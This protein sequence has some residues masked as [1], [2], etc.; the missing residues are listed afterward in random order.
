MIFDDARKGAKAERIVGYVFIFFGLLNIITVVYKG[1]E[2]FP[3]SALFMAIV[4]VGFLINQLRFTYTSEIDV[5]D[6]REVRY[7]NRFGK[8]FINIYTQNKIRCI[9]SNDNLTKYFRER[10]ADKEYAI[11]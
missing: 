10:F 11:T 3:F 1:V 9:L 7:K 8:Q 2:S 6:I 4:G 5:S